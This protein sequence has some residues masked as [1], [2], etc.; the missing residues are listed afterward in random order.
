MV[1]ASTSRPPVVELGIILAA[2]AP[3]RKYRDR[4][5]RIATAYAELWHKNSAYPVDFTA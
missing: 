4:M 2:F 1:R 5:E 3:Q